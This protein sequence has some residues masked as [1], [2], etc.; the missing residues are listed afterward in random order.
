VTVF[1]EEDTSRQWN[2]GFCNR[3]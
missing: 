2:D 3:L 1:L